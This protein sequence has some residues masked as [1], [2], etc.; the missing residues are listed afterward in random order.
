MSLLQHFHATE[1]EDTEQDFEQE[2]A[3]EVQ[4]NVQDFEPIV[5]EDEDIDKVR[6]E[7]T[8]DPFWADPISKARSTFRSTLQSSC[9]F[10][11]GRPGPR[12]SHHFRHPILHKPADAS[13]ISDE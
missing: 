12:N 10:N 13:R 1:E 5:N 11:N 8:R 3:S 2:T 6:K 7:D 9:S 4:D